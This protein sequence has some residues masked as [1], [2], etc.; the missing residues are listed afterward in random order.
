M[1]SLTPKVE[2][3]GD[4]MIL[5]LTGDKAPAGDGWLCGQLLGRAGWPGEGHLLVD[6]SFVD[7]LSSE[8]LGAIVGLHKTL[9][10][11][12]GR[13]TLFN[14]SHRVYEVFTLTRLHTVLAICREPA[15]DVPVERS[16][17]Q[18]PAREAPGGRGHPLR[19]PDD[20]WGK[21]HD[22]IEGAIRC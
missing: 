7:R 9:Q 22:P 1:N 5:T 2:R 18:G 12:G 20:P 10:T 15:P 17:R 19:P 13:L 16:Q 21:Q 14:L 3:R 6:F 4:V 8:D 11:S